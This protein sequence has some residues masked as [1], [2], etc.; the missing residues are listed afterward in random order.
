MRTLYRIR[1]RIRVSAI[2]AYRALLGRCHKCGGKPLVGDFYCQMCR[3]WA[4]SILFQ[5]QFPDY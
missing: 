5:H 3:D 4:D 1:Y 2:R